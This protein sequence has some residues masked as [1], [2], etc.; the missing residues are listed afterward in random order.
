MRKTLATM[1]KA[2]LAKELWLSLSYRT[3]WAITAYAILRGQ[4][5][6]NRQCEKGLAMIYRYCSS[7]NDKLVRLAMGSSMDSNFVYDWIQIFYR[8][9][10]KLETVHLNILEIDFYKYFRECKV[11]VLKYNRIL[12]GFLYFKNSLILLIF[13]LLYNMSIIK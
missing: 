7:R 11:I 10:E 13:L 3:A 4:Q 8:Y 5:F 1:L 6:T 12:D 9:F 2:T